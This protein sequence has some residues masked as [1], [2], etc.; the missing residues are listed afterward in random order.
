VLATAHSL[1]GV[2]LHLLGHQT[3]ARLHLETALTRPLASHIDSAGLG[4]NYNDDRTRI[5]LARTLWLNGYPDQ[6]LRLARGTVK[7]TKGHP[8]TTSIVL[9]WAICVFHWAGDLESA[10]AC[11]RKAIAHAVTHSLSPFQTVAL[12]MRGELLIRRGDVDA[13]MKLVRS[14]LEA[15][16]ADRYE[17]Y[18]A[19]LSGVL[20]AG[21]AS[22]G[23]LEEAL[24]TINAA[25]SNAEPNEGLDLPE[26]LRLRGTFLEQM[27]ETQ[28]A[29]RCFLRSCDLAERQAAASWQLRTSIDLARLRLRQHR[30][31]EA[32][33]LLAAAYARFDEGL[34]TADLKAAK[35]LLDD[36]AGPFSARA[37]RQGLLGGNP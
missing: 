23:R 4:R 37:S 17:M 12:G 31:D 27:M 7:E 30:R 16:H 13:G 18:T 25:I 32:H 14:S 22:T 5:A 11:I 8:V 35:Q 1:L 9:T 26:L 36:M 3:D 2:S 10:E 29:E 33:D 28:D 21:L 20:A 6:A 19:S 34:D 15:L 24:A